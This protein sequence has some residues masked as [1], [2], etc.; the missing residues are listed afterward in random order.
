MADEGLW[1]VREEGIGQMK[2]SRLFADLKPED[3]AE[4]MG[5]V[6]Y[7][8]CEAGQLIFQSG[9]PAE[10]L[11][12]IDAG[13]VKLVR[14]TTDKSKE[15]ILKILGPGDFVGVEAFFAGD[16]YRAYAQ[17]LE[18]TQLC[19]FHREDFLRFLEHHPSLALRFL[20]AAFQELRDTHDRLIATAYEQGEKRLA[21]LLLELCRKYGVCEGGM[22]VL[23]LRLS[24]TELAELV[25][26]RPETT[27][28]ILSRW[29]D[30]GLL[31]EAD[32][33]LV[34]QDRD[35]LAVIAQPLAKLTKPL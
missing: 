14:Q 35:R 15:Y 28:R 21:H 31:A 2:R 9:M 34:I 16:V 24:R 12:L 8:D 22:D 32:R 29:R 30:E 4:L 10:Q 6:R 26:L 19:V 33:Q 25:G 18:P 1:A 5:R 23:D 27:I 17:A 13:K 7:F 3:C 11:Y 20:T